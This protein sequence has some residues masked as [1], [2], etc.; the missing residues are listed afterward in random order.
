MKYRLITL[1][2]FNSCSE[3]VKSRILSDLQSN[4]EARREIIATAALQGLVSN[5]KLTGSA[6]DFARAAVTEAD[7]LIAA[8]NNTPLPVSQHVPN[9]KS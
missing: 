4:Y 1:E 7:A 2:D 6:E 5:T 9:A 8:L 3:L